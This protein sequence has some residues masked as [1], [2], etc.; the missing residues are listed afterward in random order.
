M[1][2]IIN[3]KQGLRSYY[4]DNESLKEMRIGKTA[5]DVIKIAGQ[6]D[7]PNRQVLTMLHAFHTLALQWL[8]TGS[9]SDAKTLSMEW[10]KNFLAFATCHGLWAFVDE[11]LQKPTQLLEKEEWSSP[12]RLALGVRPRYPWTSIMLKEIYR[13]TPAMINLL[14][15][16]GSDPNAAANHIC[17]TTW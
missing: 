14:L 4:Y 11:L 13:L 15:S 5:R 7:Q 1:S 12:L 9:I 16:R 8:I 2:Y 10:N 6:L 17:Q 3:L